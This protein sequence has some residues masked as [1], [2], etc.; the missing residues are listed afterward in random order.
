MIIEAL[1]A[2]T[3]PDH[4][5]HLD[6]LAVIEQCKDGN[7]ALAS[8]RRLHQEYPQREVYYVYTSRLEL[9][10]RERQW[11]GIRGIYATANKALSPLH[12]G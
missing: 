6:R 9:D 3:T 4:Q 8:Y 2:H 11:L 10:I 12:Y 5:R 1:A 7:T